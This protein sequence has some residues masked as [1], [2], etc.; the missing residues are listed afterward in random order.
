M[1]NDGERVGG[2]S[3]MAIWVILLLGFLSIMSFGSM[4]LWNQSHSFFK[5]QKQFEA[6][7]KV[8][9]VQSKLLK[10]EGQTFGVQLFVT[11]KHPISKELGKSMALWF[12]SQL[13]IEKPDNKLKLVRV[14][15]QEKDEFEARRIHVIAIASAVRRIDQIK[16]SLLKVGCGE[17]DVEVLTADRYGVAIRVTAQVSEKQLKTPRLASSIADQVQA[18]KGMAV[19]VV[20]VHLLDE[21]GKER[22]VQRV[23]AR[24]RQAR[25]P[26]PKATAKD[27]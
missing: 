24:G 1:S 15:S 12:F 26:V 13:F 8:K 14:T 21:S 5:I 19:G 23:T 27:H 25:P 18:V 11:N 7:Y 22:R 9:V 2:K 10:S 3:K 20:E 6:K 4:N 17:A 16:M